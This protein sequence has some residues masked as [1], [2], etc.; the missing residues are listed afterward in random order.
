MAVTG[1]QPQRAFGMLAEEVSKFRV[2]GT[3]NFFR[4]YHMRLV[5]ESVRRAKPE[6]RLDTQKWEEVNSSPLIL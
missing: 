2:H 1:A 3:T 6:I 5:N 4:C